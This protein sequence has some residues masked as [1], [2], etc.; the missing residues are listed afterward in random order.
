[1]ITVHAG[2]DAINDS[3]TSIPSPV[4]GIITACS[5]DEISLT[6]NHDDVGVG[7]T[8]WSISAPVNCFQVI[9]H[10]RTNFDNLICGSFA[11]FNVTS[12]NSEANPSQLSSTA[13]AT[14]IASMSGSVV[15]CREGN[16]V[17][18]MLIDKVSLCIYENIT[19]ELINIIAVVYISLLL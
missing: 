11:F 17:N 13:V 12:L 1:M 14:A 18:S 9:S 4:N 15:E 8:L 16:L 10:A 6:C 7:T 19:S 5:G 2:G 3:L